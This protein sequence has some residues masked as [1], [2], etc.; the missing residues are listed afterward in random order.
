MNPI[1]LQCSGARNIPA[2]LQGFITFFQAFLREHM[3]SV[4]IGQ[5]GDGPAA[6]ATV[7]DGKCRH[8]ET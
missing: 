1:S 4:A 7:G 6:P 3:S 5:N 2:V 8:I